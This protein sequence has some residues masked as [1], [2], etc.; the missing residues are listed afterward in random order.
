ML[1]FSATLSSYLLWLFLLSSHFFSTFASI[2]HIQHAHRAKA[3]ALKTSASQLI[4]Q[5]YSAFC[6]LFHISSYFMYYLL[7]NKA[8]KM[9]PFLSVQK[10]QHFK[11][12]TIDIVL[13]LR[14]YPEY[15]KS[16]GPFIIHAYFI[17]SDC[18]TIPLRFLILSIYFTNFFL[19][20]SYFHVYDIL[21]CICFCLIQNH[22]R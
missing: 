20:K 18:I 2:D 5:L 6:H 14:S 21:V 15:D 1:L 4:I 17:W 8:N 13:R 22:N 9:K 16:K 7:F 3:D 10:Q 12:L 11:A 19:S